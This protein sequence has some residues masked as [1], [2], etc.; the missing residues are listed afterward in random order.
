MNQLGKVY[1]RPWGSYLTIIQ[2]PGYQ[3]KKLFVN[4]HS[5]LSLQYH[6][7]RSE[8]WI[9]VKGE[10]LSQVGQ[11]Q[12]K[13]GVNQTVFIAKG[14][15]HRIINQTSEPAE[16]VEVQCGNYLGE[17]DIVRLEDDYGRV[18]VSD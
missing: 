9:V 6:N 4:G 2:E 12:L 11:D 7:H 10:I 1:T 5:K 13:L 17:D 3:V 15:R 18:P 16:L 14:V 8:H